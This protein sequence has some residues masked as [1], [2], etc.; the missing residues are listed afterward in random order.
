MAK[1][2]MLVVL[3][4]LSLS[5]LGSA[6]LFGPP[7]VLKPLI[8]TLTRTPGYTSIL[9]LLKNRGTDRTSLSAGS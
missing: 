6:Q 9:N 1:Y 5:S 2:A 8:A 7:A 3:S 4:L